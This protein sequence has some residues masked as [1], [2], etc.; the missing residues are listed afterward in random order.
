M[1]R[2]SVFL[3]YKLFLVYNYIAFASVLFFLKEAFMKTL[4]IS[5]TTGEGH[6]SCAKAIKEVY[7][8]NGHECDIIDGL[9]LVSDGLANFV[10][11]G[12]IT[13]YRHFPK[14][15]NFGYKLSEK[16]P[17]AFSFGSVIYKIL[18][19][20][21]DD[22][23]NL[24]KEK[25]YDTVICTHP[26]AAVILTEMQ[27]R[28]PLPI[29]TAFVATDYTCS[30]SVKESNLDYYFIPTAELKGD[31]ISEN[32]PDSK[33]IPSGIP[34]RQSFYD[35]VDTALAKS[36]LG[37]PTEHRHIVV[38]CGSMGCGP[39]ASFTADISS[40]IDKN[41]TI[42]VICGSN[43]KLK[44]RLEKKTKRYPNVIIH[45]YIKNMPQMLAS[46]DLY[47]TKPG[48]ISTTEA[49]STETPMLFVNTV[50]GCETYNLNH[51]CGMGVAVSAK[52]VHELTE[53][54]IS[55]INEDDILDDINLRLKNAEKT[56]SANTV[57][58]V[59]NGLTN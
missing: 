29:S 51:F 35:K 56:N 45:G 36:E 25:G 21:S 33:L 46:A 12:H 26:F 57:Y 34:I 55:L 19:K 3:D 58:R 40:K 7:D 42:S 2:V 38:M 23:Y 48:G 47:I 18:A 31:F 15:F 13:L 37:I 39:L 14:L 43:I 41:T 6:N 17:A 30:P 59:L 1:F 32:I 16:H 5:C 54:C 50:A 49:V 20:G 53:K 11:W 4:I 24:I 10:S 44:A 8:I 9:T 28:Y 22:L 52:N 27:N